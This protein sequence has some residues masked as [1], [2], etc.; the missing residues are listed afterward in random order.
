MLWSEEYIVMMSPTGSYFRRSSVR[1]HFA[2]PY[3]SLPNSS[4]SAG[5]DLA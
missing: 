2:T 1:I 3:S 5:P 4:R